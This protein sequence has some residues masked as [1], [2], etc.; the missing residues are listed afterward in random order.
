MENRRISIPARDDGEFSGYLALPEGGSGPGIV[1]AQEIFGVNRVMRQVA[2]RFAEEGYVV[3]VPD[4]FW[5]IEPDIDLGYSEEEWQRAFE[6]FQTF[7]VDQGVEDM[8][9]ALDALAALPECTDGPAVLGYCL[10]GKL[11]Y[12]TAC[13]HSPKAAVAY[14]GV[15]IEE[16]LDESAGIECPTVLHVAGQDKFVPPEA[17]AAIEGQFADHPQ[18]NVFVYP[19]VDHAF[20]REGK[21]VV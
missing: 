8:G 19:G 18:V 2:D 6:L 3:L 9:A 5:R 4:L 11:S 12:L 1:V 17:V 14:Y 13:R 15:G 21:S 10:G 7:D 20:A 16:S